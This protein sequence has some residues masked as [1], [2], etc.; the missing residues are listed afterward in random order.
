MAPGNQYY[1]QVII[2]FIEVV[3]RVDIVYDYFPEI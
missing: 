2:Q 3:I 1:K